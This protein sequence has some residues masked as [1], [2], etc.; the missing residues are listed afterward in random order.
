MEFINE[1]SVFR[2]KFEIL[3]EMH[4]EKIQNYLIEN[5]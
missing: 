1:K 4:E 3:T 2:K 5:V